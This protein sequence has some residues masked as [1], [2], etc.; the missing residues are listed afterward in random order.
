MLVLFLLIL[1]SFSINGQTTL[2]NA[3]F[4]TD[5][6]DNAWA[7]SAGAGSVWIRDT[8]ANYA[9]ITPWIKY[10][11]DS[12][13]D[14]V[15]P[16]IDLTG[17]NSLTLDTDI[18]VD[19]QLGMDGMRIEYRISGGAWNVLGTAAS[20]FYND[21]DVS[22]IGAGA[23]GWSGE[24]GLVFFSKSL[25]LSAFDGSFDGASNVQFRFIFASDGSNQKNGVAF[26]NFIIL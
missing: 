13:S 11:K 22:A 23:D 9:R 16:V 1:T 14:F 24:S 3:N 19:T 17:Y 8:G 4:L 15:S 2:F 21:T 7:Q 18:I 12:Y 26:D 5:V 10:N 25:D 20:G 6:D